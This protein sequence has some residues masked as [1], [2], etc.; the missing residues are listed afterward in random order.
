MFMNEKFKYLRISTMRKEE[1]SSFLYQYM[2]LLVFRRGSQEY[3]VHFLEG[4][5]RLFCRICAMS[6]SLYRTLLPND[7]PVPNGI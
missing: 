7:V 2:G 5:M 4:A 3:V 1:K 6:G